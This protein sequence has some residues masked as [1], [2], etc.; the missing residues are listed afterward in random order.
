M[1]FAKIGVFGALMVAAVMATGCAYKDPVKELDAS[2]VFAREYYQP[3]G[4]SEVKVSVYA[5]KS[6]EVEISLPR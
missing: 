6:G 4:D 2:C 3:M 1:K 5:C